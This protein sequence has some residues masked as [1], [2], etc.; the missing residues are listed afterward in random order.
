MDPRRTDLDLLV[1][2]IALLAFDDDDPR[3]RHFVHRRL[4]SS[5]QQWP[6]ELRDLIDELTMGPPFRGMRSQRMREIATAVLDGYRGG[7]EDR[8]EK[9]EERMATL[10]AGMEQFRQSARAQDDR[11]TQIA[12]DLHSYLWLASTGADVSQVETTRF[13]PVRMFV[14]NPVPDDGSLDALVRAFLALAQPLGLDLAE[15]LPPR[16]GSWWKTLVLKTKAWMTQPEVQDVTAK[17]KAA[18]ELH[19]LDKPQAEANRLQ[20][21]GAAQVI[22]ALT[23]V[24][25]PCAVQAGSLL[26]VKTDGVDGRASIVARTL[27]PMELRRLEENRS[28]LGR[29]C[30]L[31]PWLATAS[32]DGTDGTDI[33]RPA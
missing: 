26:V 10:E 31:L 27:S 4:R 33:A 18:L 1:V 15:D 9:T 11:A 19:Y 20:A 5:E 3:L 16:S 22:T 32:T 30:D 21:E 13:V 2:L 25:G 28:M 6:P 12:A 8:F 7:V 23:A 17:A 29:P 14:A 24:P